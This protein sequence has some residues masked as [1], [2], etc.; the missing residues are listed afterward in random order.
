ML[1]AKIFCLK[2]CYEVLLQL[3][4][5]AVITLLQI[6][7]EKSFRF[8][9]YA[10]LRLIRLFLPRVQFAIPINDEYVDRMEKRIEDIESRHEQDIDELDSRH[11]RNI[12]NLK[13][14]H[15]TDM[16]KT[17]ESH[18][19]ELQ[20]LNKEHEMEINEME[21]Q[22]EL[23]MKDWRSNHQKEIQELKRENSIQRDLLKKQRN[24]IELAQRELC[25]PLKPHCRC[26]GRFKCERCTKLAE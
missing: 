2:K 4:K 10:P 9:L 8:S 25:K 1:I 13:K 17:Q 19:A 7:P 24:D 15:R 6:W 26:G 18:E 14:R 5:V 3:L 20:R 12:S 23:E 21:K 22:H 11:L 16:K